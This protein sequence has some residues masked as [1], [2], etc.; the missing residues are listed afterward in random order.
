MAKKRLEPSASLVDSVQLIEA[1]AAAW[2]TL[3]TTNFIRIL[4]LFYS[5]SEGEVM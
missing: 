2:L 5:G 1:A 3:T 4:I